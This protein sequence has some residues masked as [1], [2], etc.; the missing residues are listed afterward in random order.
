MY[1]VYCAK[2]IYHVLQHCKLLPCFLHLICRA[3]SRHSVNHLVSDP[4]FHFSAT[5]PLSDYTVVCS[6]SVLFMGSFLQDDDTGLS[7]F[8]YFQISAKLFQRTLQSCMRTLTA[9]RS[10]VL[11]RILVLALI[12]PN[13][14]RSQQEWPNVFYSISKIF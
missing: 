9:Q 5:V 7:A 10:L 2:Q 11:Q 3:G 12:K 8:K 4:Y 14:H 13:H 6:L 1:F